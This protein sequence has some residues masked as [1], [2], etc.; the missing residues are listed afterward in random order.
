MRVAWWNELSRRASA[1]VKAARGGQPITLAE[2]Y[3][4]SPQGD[5]GAQLGPGSAPQPQPLGG[6]PRQ[7]QYRPGWNI[8]GP[9]GEGRVDAQM[10]RTLADNYDLLRRCIEIRKNEII[11]LEWDIVPTEKNRRK[12]QLLR[13]KHAAQI[14]QVKQFF[15]SPEAY[16][17]R[18]DGSWVRQG[19]IPFSDWLNALLEDYLVGDWL[20]IYPRYKLNGEMLAL[21][22]I[23][24][25]L[26]KP[27]LGLDGRVPLPPLPAYNQWLHGRIA[28]QFQAD[29]LIYRPRNR[30]NNTPYGFSHVEQVLAHVNEALRFQMWTSAYFT[31]GSL[32][33]GFFTS[34]EGW[35]ID[36]IRE[37]NDYINATLSGDPK[38]LRQFHLLPSGTTH[39]PVK[40]FTFD[41]QFARYL[42][43][44][45]CGL[46]D[47]QPIEVGFTPKSGLGGAGFSEGQKQVSARKSLRPTAKWVAGIF[48]DVIHNL[49]GL[50]E[51][52][53][54]WTSL[55]EE[56]EKEHVETDKERL[57]SGQATLDQILMEHGDDPVGMDTPV[58]LV[59]NTLLFLPD[60]LAGQEQGQAALSPFGGMPPGAPP[61]GGGGEPAPEGDEESAHGHTPDG[62]GGTPEDGAMLDGEDR[63][64]TTDDR[65]TKLAEEL[66]RWK[67]LALKAAKAGKRPRPFVSRVIPPALQAVVQERLTKAATPD[68]VKQAFS[69]G[70]VQSRNPAEIAGARQELEQT[71]TDFLA[72]EKARLAEYIVGRVFGYAK[73]VMPDVQKDAPPPPAMPADLMERYDWSSWVQALFNPTKAQ[74]KRIYAQA[75]MDALASIR[76][77]ENFHLRDEAAEAYAAQRAAELVG[78]RWVDGELLD[79]P[80]QEYAVTESTRQMLRGTVQRALEEGL[81]PAELRDR[82][83]SD[84]AFSSTRAL[85]IARTE[86]GTAYNRGTIGGYRD[87]GE[88]DE[89]DVVD[90]DGDEECAAANGQRWTLEE[91]EADPLAHPN[92]LPGDVLV[93]APNLE[94]AFARWFDGEMVVLR[95]AA[96]DLLTCTPNHPILTDRGWVAAGQ[97]EEGDHVVRCLDREGIARLLDPNNHQMPTRIEEI[98]RSL[99]ES[100]PMASRCMPCT[101]EDFHGDGGSSE[102]Y[103]VGTNGLRD[104]RCDATRLEHAG[105]SIFQITSMGSGPFLAESAPR[106]ILGGAPHSP[107]GVVSGGG[108][109]GPLAL[110][111]ACHPVGGAFTPRTEDVT[112]ALEPTTEAGALHADAGGDLIGRLSGLIAPVKVVGVERRKFAGHVYN[113]QTAQ[114]WYL[115]NNILTHN[116]TRAFIP[117]VKGAD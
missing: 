89:V 18:R 86:T 76:L 20:T 16:M 93:F 3:A 32:P 81:S 112:A 54:A 58:V 87:S 104:D 44:K 42:V 67:R 106:Q 59:G 23:D 13:E 85:T 98:A 71:W 61:Q 115:A 73:G 60:L 21:E 107:D 75:G 63:T 65:A 66:G 103:V 74:L 97:V 43:E 17:V 41:D 109:T 22:R 92:C 96:D 64:V 113:L 7:Y 12:S 49:F 105:E 62:E 91:A 53:F 70:P 37:F 28:A 1:V 52:E 4:L 47:V 90:G 78:K 72:N 5:P 27:L 39:I 116:C 29:E 46:M 80:R 9:P 88:V 114:N 8:P 101:P 111:G 38:A 95:T 100:S 31:D 55:A 10:L 25:A 34:P 79:N 24:G 6:D 51:L 82:I 94:A 84:F 117:V 57:L 11:G 40:P 69:L 68:R 48:N 15:K 19:L 110:T 36:Q 45:T 35:T 14:D 50:P 108:Q 26:I 2:Q 56:D 77:G 99:L 33:E 102:V 83:E 30:R